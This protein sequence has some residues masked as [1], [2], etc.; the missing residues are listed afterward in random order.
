MFPFYLDQNTAISFPLL[1]STRSVRMD[2]TC[3][4]LTL[5]SAFI[6]NLYFSFLLSSGKGKNNNPLKLVVWNFQGSSCLL[7]FSLWCYRIIENRNS[8]LTRMN[9]FLE[10]REL[11]QFLKFL[12]IRAPLYF[13]TSSSLTIHFLRAFQNQ[14]RL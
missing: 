3:V 7:Y 13:I 11:I 8:F 4:A 14:N 9:S 5:Q 10:N 2:N 6:N 12:R 1:Q